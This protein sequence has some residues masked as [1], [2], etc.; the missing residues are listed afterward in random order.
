[1][2]STIGYS[3]ICLGFL[4]IISSLVLMVVW[5]IPSLIDELSGRKAKRQIDRM[6]KLN[7]ASSSLNITDTAEFYK[8]M[9]GQ[10]DFSLSINDSFGNGSELSKLVDNPYGTVGGLSKP[11]KEVPKKPE[12]FFSD[13]ATEMI[14]FDEVPKKGLNIQII[15]EQSSI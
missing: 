6:K 10:S 8:S 1:M 15:V 4:L 7:I 13:G 11:E 5:K 3:L 2:L 9:N 14:E 12:N